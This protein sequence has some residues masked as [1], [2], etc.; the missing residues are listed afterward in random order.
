MSKR[1][2]HRFILAMLLSQAAAGSG[3]AQDVEE[4]TKTFKQALEFGKEGRFDSAIA[5]M[6]KIRAAMPDFPD[7]YRKLGEWYSEVDQHR[8]ALEM[9]KEYRQRAPEDWRAHEG[10]I[11]TYQALGE[12]GLRDQEREE[13]F[14]LRKSS[15]IPELHQLTRYCR[16]RFRVGGQRVT[17]YESFE[18]SAAQGRIYEFWVLQYKEGYDLLYYL[19]SSDL[20]T[21]I[22][23]DLGEVRATERRYF[24]DY[25]IAEGE[26][27]KERG[28]LEFFDL[29]QPPSYEFVRDQ[30]VKRLAQPPGEW[31]S[32]SVIVE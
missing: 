30:V 17:A 25:N 5:E 13:L 18:P 6:K 3:L 29:E 4:L 16:E 9:W 24:L 28:L 7:A 27:F 15:D 31:K 20:E 22:G 11:Q 1:F 12:T 26:R 32:K 19:G 8:K 23:R 10:L 2:L 14:R 21:Q